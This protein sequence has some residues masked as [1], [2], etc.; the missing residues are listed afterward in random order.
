MDELT[1]DLERTPDFTLLRFTGPLSMRS[2]P[3]AREALTKA[4]LDSPCVLVDLSALWLVHH[5]CAHVFP[6]ALVVAGSWPWS[7]LALFGAPSALRAALDVNRVTSAVPHCADR[8]AAW[9]QTHQ[10]PACVRLGREFPPVPEVLGAARAMIG[11]AAAAGNVPD[12]VHEVARLV[13]NELL[14]NAIEHAGT[15]CRLTAEVS[16]TAFGIR[17]RDY[18]PARLP[19]RRPH[20]PT[21]MRGRGLQLVDALAQAWGVDRHLDG[22][23]VWARFDAT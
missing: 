20:D 23:T 6:S 22:K 14:T 21:A 7:K 11:D 9:R 16:G 5:V 18:F 4:L 17:V 8:A 3:R 13:G 1:I 12:S 15:S 2:V 10:R 19:R